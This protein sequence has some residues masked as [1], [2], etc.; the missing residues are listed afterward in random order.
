MIRANNGLVGSSTDPPG[1][2]TVSMQLPRTRVVRSIVIV[3][4]WVCMVSGAAV[5]MHEFVGVYN[6]YQI[7]FY[8]TPKRQH[9][10]CQSGFQITFHYNHVKL[11]S[12]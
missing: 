10:I 5:A 8:L 2:S 9:Y 4:G 12:P 7:V 6:I 11:E 1:G 3:L